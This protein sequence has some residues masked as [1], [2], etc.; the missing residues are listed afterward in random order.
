VPL[1]GQWA[2]SLF[3]LEQFHLLKLLA[4]AALSMVTGTAMLAFARSRRLDS[5]LLSHFAIQCAAW[6][7]VDA[8][9]VAW[10][11]RGLAL[12]DLAG[13]VALDRFVWLNIG[14]DAGYVAV[15]MTLVLLGWRLG[16]RLG[17]VGAGLGVVVQGLAL[18]V[19]DLQLA[20]GIV[21]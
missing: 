19:L 18:L 21:R 7:A 6:G 16:R 9:I 3:Q 14:L 15:G 8:A 11:R 4:W 13:A 1:T 2:D 12:R 17:L 10:A 5:P 20:A